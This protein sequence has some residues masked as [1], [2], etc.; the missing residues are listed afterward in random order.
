[1]YTFDIVMNTQNITVPVSCLYM[2]VP[3]R[4]YALYICSHWIFKINMY[5]NV[6]YLLTFCER[7]LAY[8]WWNCKTLQTGHL[9]KRNIRNEYCMCWEN[10]SKISWK[11]TNQ[12]PPWAEKSGFL[13]LDMR[14]PVNNLT[15]K[16][17]VFITCMLHLHMYM[18][19]HVYN[20]ACSAIFTENFPK[21]M[22]P[23]FERS[24]G[25][26][27][28]ALSIT[29]TLNVATIEAKTCDVT[30]SAN[31]LSRQLYTFI[32]VRRRIALWNIYTHDSPR[33]RLVPE[34]STLLEAKE[35][36]S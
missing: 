32:T 10:A 17:R 4:L 8:S 23:G 24:V 22:R 3:M 9:I 20:C 7:L 25:C 13:L 27:W 2:T 16:L 36:P 6:F 31:A 14:Y 26:P 19:N 33:Q 34:T 11:S 30:K 29:F 12:K 18:Y 15:Y 5:L 35:N 1:M 28:I 21:L